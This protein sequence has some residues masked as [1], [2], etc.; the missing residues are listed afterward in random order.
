MWLS[1]LEQ[2][3]TEGLP[4]YVRDYLAA[5]A[6]DER[7]RDAVA[8]AWSGAPDAPPPATAATTVLG[9][10]LATPVLIAPTAQQVALDPR[11]EQATAEGAAA[12]G[13]LLG[14]STNTGVPFAHVAAAGAPWWFQVYLLSDLDVT[15]RHV[16]RAVEAGAEALLVTVD[17]IRL[18]AAPGVEPHEWPRDDPGRTRLA[19]LTPD[20]RRALG[21]R[22]GPEPTVERLAWLR[23][24]A[25]VPVVAKG[26]VT[27][28]QASAYVDAG[29]AGVVVSTHGA[30]VPATGS[31]IAAL[32]GVVA[33]VGDR[34][35]VYLD[36][37]VRSG[38]H[39][40]AALAAGARAV[41]V[42]RPA[43]WGLATG[44]A[45]GVAAVID[46]L[47]AETLA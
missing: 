12:S 40:R 45:A 20:E 41:F 9:R 29:A 14:V 2:R 19:N 37:G 11:G 46:R 6:L 4:W 1:E 25:G 15:R 32:P 18:G 17:R 16:E 22:P 5:T 21:G 42:G 36:S 3:A 26:V 35:E 30:R 47:T 28:E 24:F 38:A 31:S 43:M 34:A 33:S 44:G 10:Q 23:E 8:A 27:P 7:Q 13:T 39:V